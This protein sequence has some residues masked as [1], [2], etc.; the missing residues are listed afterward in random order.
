LKRLIKKSYHDTGNRDSAMIYIN[1]Q[2]IK[3]YTHAE[4]VNQYFKENK[5]KF[6]ANIDH[7]DDRCDMDYELKRN[8]KVINSSFGCINI[9]GYDAFIEKDTLENITINELANKLK[10]QFPEYTIYEDTDN[11]VENISDYRKIAKNKR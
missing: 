8:E 1:D 7:I 3:G 2:F 10:Q 6:K 9:S 11:W 5:I 4:C